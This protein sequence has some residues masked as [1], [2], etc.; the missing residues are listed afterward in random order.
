M[1][2]PEAQPDGGV[3]G[4]GRESGRLGG[5]EMAVAIA[6]KSEHPSCNVFRKWGVAY[7]ENTPLSNVVQIGVQI[8]VTRYH[9]TCNMVRTGVLLRTR[10]HPTFVGL[11]NWGTPHF[12][13]PN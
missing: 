2:N 8:C 6:S 1:A 13:H 12:I 11:S 4:R 9:P 7:C 5:G 3:V 10:H